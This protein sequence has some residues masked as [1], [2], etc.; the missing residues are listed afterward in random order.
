MQR[1]LLNLNFNSIEECIS[2]IIHDSLPL[3]Y[4]VL[5]EE[6]K[7][8]KS[9]TPGITL[10]DIFNGKK[11]IFLHSI[12]LIEKTILEYLIHYKPLPANIAELMKSIKSVKKI[13]NI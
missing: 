1:S 8:K 4:T 5:L 11:H 7:N 13:Y 12:E 3:N 6:L 9:N 10:D 2:F